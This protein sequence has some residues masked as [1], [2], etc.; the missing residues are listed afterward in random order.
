MQLLRDDMIER[1]QSYVC[2]EEVAAQTLCVYTCAMASGFGFAS[3]VIIVIS[4]SRYATYY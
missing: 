4:N 2:P 1:L 3:L